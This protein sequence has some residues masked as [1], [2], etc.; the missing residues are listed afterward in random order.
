MIKIIII[1]NINENVINNNSINN[2]IN[3]DRYIKFD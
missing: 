1:N 3:N 2:I